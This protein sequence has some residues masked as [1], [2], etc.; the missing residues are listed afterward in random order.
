[1]YFLYLTSTLKFSVHA[2]SRAFNVS[3]MFYRELSSKISIDVIKIG[4]RFIW[5]C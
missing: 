4:S 3:R 2:E 5:D 1:M